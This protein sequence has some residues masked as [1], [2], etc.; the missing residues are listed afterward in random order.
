MSASG[1]HAAAGARAAK[2][3]GAAARQA[4]MRAQIAQQTSVA[5]TGLRDEI[6]GRKD[7]RERVANGRRQ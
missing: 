3:P 7:E 1:P 2:S 5:R 6:T 4:V